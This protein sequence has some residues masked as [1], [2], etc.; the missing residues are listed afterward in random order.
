MI[1]LYQY[2]SLQLPIKVGQI[3]YAN[4]ARKSANALKIGI[5]GNSLM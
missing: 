1:S 3:C 4:T 2:A 5:Q